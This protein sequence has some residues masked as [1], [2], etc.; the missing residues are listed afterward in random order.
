METTELDISD[1]LPRVCEVLDDEETITAYTQDTSEF[2]AT[3]QLPESKAFIRSFVK[4]IA[5]APG[6]ATIPM[7]GDNPLRGGEAE[8]VILGGP[9]RFPDHCYF[10]RIG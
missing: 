3:G 8:D 7:P 4:E 6:T 9:V 1:V 10:E 5:V 2:L